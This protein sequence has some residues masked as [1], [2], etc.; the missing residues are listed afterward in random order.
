MA[1]VVAQFILSFSKPLCL[2]LQKESTDVVQAYENAKACCATIRVQRSDDKFGEVWK[3]AVAIGAEL[4]V[5]LRKPR[6]ATRSRYRINA[7]RY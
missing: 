6:A 3:K 2:A 1:L 4:D 5:E 7:G